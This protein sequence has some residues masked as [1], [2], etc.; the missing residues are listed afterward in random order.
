[1]ELFH[2]ENTLGDIAYLITGV[3]ENLNAL[4]ARVIVWGSG[5]GGKLAVWARQKYPHLINGAWSSSGLFQPDPIT[6][7]NLN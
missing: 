7:S 5:T 2:V 3:R 1:M 6:P 4:N